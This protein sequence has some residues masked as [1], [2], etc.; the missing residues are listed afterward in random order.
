[1]EFF[2]T[3]LGA[4]VIVALAVT[5]GVLRRR[6]PP[7]AMLSWI[8]IVIFLP[9]L[10]TFFY[11]L[12][13]ENRIERTAQRKLRRI[14]KRAELLMRKT[15][16]QLAQADSVLETELPEDLKRV[17]LIG[18]RLE[19]MPA[20][21]GNHI[22][23]FQ[24]P[25]S[26]YHALQESIE[27][28]RHHVHLEFYIWRA[29][30]IGTRFRDLV[31]KKSKEGVQCRV[32]LDSVGA[33][34]LHRGFL[35]PFYDHGVEVAYFLPF[36]SMRRRWGPHLR[37]HRKIAVI[38]GATAMVG[39]Q[40][41]GDEYRG[42]AWPSPWHDIQ[43]RVRGPAAL[44]LQQ[45]F[46]EDWLFATRRA[47]DEEE[48]FPVPEP[49]GD[50]ILQVL[51][52]GPHQDVSIL[53]R[54]LV[55][56][57]S[58]ARA[59][60][61]MVTPYFV[62]SDVVRMALVQASFRGVS[63]NVVLPEQTD[64]RVTLHAAR[65]FY[66]ELMHEDVII[67]EFQNGMLHSKVVTVDDRWYICGSANMDVRSFRLNFEVTTAGY[68]RDIATRLADIIDGYCRQ[69]RKVELSELKDVPLTRTLLEGACRVLTPQL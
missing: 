1:M 9:F 42:K 8:L 65:S 56:A 66:P 19:D 50:G 53:E 59:S 4:H 43:M 68:D 10:G 61:R 13:G 51:P 12:L 36:Y 58:G 18:R 63:V 39:S 29:D 37:N 16:R 5:A 48:H 24:E 38:D 2:L 40:N 35:K 22:E 15:H 7:T 3:M 26:I 69:S 52:T 49:Q 27:G 14:T 21:Q 54:L 47:L 32:L 34:F 6:R 62:P 28:A 64:R 41:I 67:Y 57:I 30:E 20:T 17:E 46:A 25:D 44:F 33:F 11:F 55:A 45:T 60:V 31:V 23:I